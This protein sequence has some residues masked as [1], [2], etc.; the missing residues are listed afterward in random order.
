MI[1][2]LRRC[3]HPVPARVV[4]EQGRPVG[5]TTERRG[6]AGGTVLAAAGP[7]RS[8]GN[9]WSAGASKYWHRD[10]WDVAL[11]DGALYRLGHDHETD[12]WFIDGI[13]D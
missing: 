7:W 6:F 9:W 10:E 8:S 5:V 12:C 2:V 3:R 1:S 4:M 11:S 13:V